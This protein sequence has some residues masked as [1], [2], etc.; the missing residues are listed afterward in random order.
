MVDSNTTQQYLDAQTQLRLHLSRSLSNQK[1]IQMYL[2]VLDGFDQY[3]E[4][5]GKLPSK[6]LPEYYQMLTKVPP[7]EKPAGN[8]L[9]KKARPLHMMNDIL[10][11]NAAKRK[12]SYTT[13][14]CPES[15]QEELVQYCS[16][17]SSC[18]KSEGTIRTRSGRIKVLFLFLSNNG[19]GLIEGI[20]TELLLDFISSLS[21]KYS[22]QG[23]ASIL[24]TL[25]NFF[26]CP[27]ILCRLSV[28][29]MPLLKGL[30]SRKH[31]RLGSYYTGDE[32]R[33]VMDSVDRSTNPGKTIYLMMLLACVYGLRVSDIRGLQLSSL[34]WRRRTIELF[35]YKTKRCIELPMTHDVCLALL[36]Y[37]KNV[38]PH[39][40][41]PHIFIK[42]RG[43]HEPYSIH[44]HF[45][46]KVTV[47]FKRAGINTEG[48]HHGL[49]ALRHSLASGLLEQD[50]PI[51][52]VAVILGHT[53]VA[54]TKN[55]IWSDIAHLKSAALEVPPYDQ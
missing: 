6:A 17:M 34:H 9:R 48:K 41:D 22:S 50:V 1:L 21:G 18:Q 47:F 12:Y 23:K 52:E 39:I 31:E 53:T 45:G 16:W 11:G 46:A 5:S 2:S 49:H 19:C 43:H 10:N 44:D 26:N 36:D 55:Y 40:Q 32:I 28:D 54:A 35:Q 15:F 25:R 4:A 33:K 38:R 7:F 37:I 27:D 24:Y 8:H 30:H 13:A 29:P 14:A 51:H 20:S 42:H 3:V